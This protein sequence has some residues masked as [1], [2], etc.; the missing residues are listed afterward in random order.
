VVG[1]ALLSGHGIIGA[2]T[3]HSEHPFLP[4]EPDRSPIRR[5]RGRLTSGVTLWTASGEGRPAGLT[6]SSMMV[7]DGDP[8]RVVA[9]LD[10]DSDLWAAAAE[11]RTVALSWLTYE[12]RQ[13]AD[14]FAGVAPAP[15]GPFKLAKWRDTE[16]GPVLDG[17]ATWAG[18]RLVDDAP[19][20]VGWALLVEAVV[21]HAV[22]EEEQ[23]AALAHRRGRYVRIE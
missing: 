12:H 17:A 19:Q 22:L 15:G 1:A 3:I 8:G 10:P 16:W 14:A 6:V 13:L 7:A 23:S 18:C 20:E 9:L 2:V 5:L 21:E 11:A 4:P